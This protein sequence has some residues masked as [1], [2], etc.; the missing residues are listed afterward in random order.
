MDKEESP[1]KLKILRYGYLKDLQEEIKSYFP[2]DML[3]AIGVFDVNSMPG[4]ESDIVTVNGIELFL[5]P[6]WSIM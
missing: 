3:D 1:P 4:T 6:N 2:S 5:K